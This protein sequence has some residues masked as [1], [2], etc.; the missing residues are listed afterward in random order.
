MIYGTPSVFLYRVYVVVYSERADEG[1]CSQ[2]Y[3]LLPE[4]F[5]N[6]WHR[7]VGFYL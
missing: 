6:P 3:V 4:G 5:L 2:I 7:N 1:G